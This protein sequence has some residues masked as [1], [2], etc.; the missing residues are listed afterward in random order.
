MINT[1]PRFPNAAAFRTL[2]RAVVQARVAVQGAASRRTGRRSGSRRTAKRCHKIWGSRTPKE[3]EEGH[4]WRGP[5]RSSTAARE[6]R[7]SGP[8][9]VSREM[10]EREVRRDEFCV[11]MEPP[12]EG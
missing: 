6:A 11:R 2:V 3:V 10:R 8:G 7:R 4:R 5:K 12:G 1:T 9:R